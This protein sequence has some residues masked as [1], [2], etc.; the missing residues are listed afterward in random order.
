MAGWLLCWIGAELQ[1]RWLAAKRGRRQQGSQTLRLD[2][3][4]DPQKVGC[5]SRRGR[6]SSSASSSSCLSL[7]HYPYCCQVPCSCCRQSPRRRC[8]CR[9]CPFCRCR[10]RCHCRCY[11]LVGCDCVQNRP[12]DWLLRA[13]TALRHPSD[14]VFQPQAL[15]RRCRS[16]LAWLL[17]LP[18]RGGGKGGESGAAQ[19][20]GSPH[21]LKD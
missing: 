10:H 3:Q 15:P 19:T 11:G 20:C 21:S 12:Q 5:A 8:W 14:L 2:P 13:Q 4:L 18:A 6:P 17:H 9:S 16:A 7:S 1:R